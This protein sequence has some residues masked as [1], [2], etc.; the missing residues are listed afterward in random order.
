LQA[1]HSRAAE[2][3]YRVRDSASQ[4]AA[5]SGRGSK[6]E[7]RMKNEE[8][9]RR[10][11]VAPPFLRSSFALRT[12]NLSSLPNALLLPFREVPALR[13][14]LVRQPA[15]AVERRLAASAGRGDGLAIDVI[16]DVTA[17][18]DALDVRYRGVA[19]RQDDVAALV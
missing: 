1:N 7:V 3:E 13:D 4:G 18:E 17:G 11:Y 6:C 15:L 2:D 14:P 16:D 9:G 5:P 12:S 10:D 8:G 19:M